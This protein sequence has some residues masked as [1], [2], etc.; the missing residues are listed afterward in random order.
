MA[1]RMK[2]IP[3][4]R[5]MIIRQLP[6]D[7][8]VANRIIDAWEAGEKPLTPIDAGCFAVCDEVVK[9]VNKHK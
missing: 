2:F 4:I 7:E 5:A 9:E 8:D 6:V 3:E 1:E